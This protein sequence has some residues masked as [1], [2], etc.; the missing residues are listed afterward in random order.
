M[1]NTTLSNDERAEAVEEFLLQEAISAGVIKEIKVKIIHQRKCLK[2]L[3]ITQEKVFCLNYLKKKGLTQIIKAKLFIKLS[4]V[5]LLLKNT[6][7]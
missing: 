3:F 6:K 1:E 7:Q 2:K 5:K 4:I